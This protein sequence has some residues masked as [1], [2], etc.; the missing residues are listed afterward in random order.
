MTP[1]YAVQEQFHGAH[2]VKSRH[3]TRLGARYA[4]W[5]AQRRET[6]LIR[7]GRLTDQASYTVTRHA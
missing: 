5:R 3:R 1:R 2:Y 4:A 6:H 7:A